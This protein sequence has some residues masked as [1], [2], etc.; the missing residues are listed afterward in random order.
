SSKVRVINDQ[1]RLTYPEGVEV[2]HGMQFEAENEMDFQTPFIRPIRGSQ[3]L[4]LPWGSIYVL[5]I[6][7]RM[8]QE[9]EYLDKIRPIKVFVLFNLILDPWFTLRFCFLS[10]YY[11]IKTRLHILSQKKSSIMTKLKILRE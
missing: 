5:K 6:V 1:T 8:K 3:F 4:N 9:R 10:A 2:H 7:N 11:F